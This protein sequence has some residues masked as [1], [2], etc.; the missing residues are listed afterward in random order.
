M[1]V[2]LAEAPSQGPLPMADRSDIKVHEFSVPPH[3]ANPQASCQ[4]LQVGQRYSCQR[5]I[6]GH[7]LRVKTVS[8]H[9]TVAPGQQ[10]IISRRAVSRVEKKWLL[11]ST[12][13]V[14]EGIKEYKQPGI[15]SH[16]P[17]G[18]VA[19]KEMTEPLA[20]GS[21]QLTFFVQISKINGI[22]SVHIVKSKLATVPTG[23]VIQRY[24]QARYALRMRCRDLPSC[25]SPATGLSLSPGEYDNGQGAA[26]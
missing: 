21:I 5:H 9:M 11:I 1:R 18:Q 24:R 12:Q 8:C 20:G 26:E 3:A 17:T 14:A 2:P 6:G 7:S 23:A 16:F 22:T 19:A 25:H 10:T 4:V 13:T 15:D